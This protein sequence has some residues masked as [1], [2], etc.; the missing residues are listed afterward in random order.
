MKLR[1]DWFL[2]N[3]WLMLEMEYLSSEAEHYLAWA[4]TQGILWTVL[5]EALSVILCNMDIRT[6]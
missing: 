6:L 1:K 5:C 4:A 3:M 2:E